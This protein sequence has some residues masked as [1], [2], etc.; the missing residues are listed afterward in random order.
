LQ[1]GALAREVYQYAISYIKEKKPDVEKN[2]VKSVGFGVSTF[3]IC[4]ENLDQTTGK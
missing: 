3:F 4:T 1:D 2:F